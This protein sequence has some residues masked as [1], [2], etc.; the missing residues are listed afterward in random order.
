MAGM[1]LQS[2]VVSTFLQAAYKASSSCSAASGHV[3]LQS[4]SKVMYGRKERGTSSRQGH[5]Q[6]A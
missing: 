5:E 4:L 1:D 3:R 2:V 6:G